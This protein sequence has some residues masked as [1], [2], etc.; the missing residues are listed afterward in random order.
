M[1]VSYYQILGIEKTAS[2]RDIKKAYRKLALAYH[3]DRNPGQPDIEKKFIEISTAYQVLTNSSER[4]KYD[5][6]LE[7]GD[8]ET[9]KTYW[10]NQTTKRRPPPPAYY[11]RKAGKVEYTKKAKIL[12]GIIVA[13]MLIIIV[14]VPIFL[15]RTTSKYN[16]AEAQLLYGKNFY[17]EALQKYDQSITEFGWKNAEACTFAGY[18]LTWN[19]QNPKRAMKYLKK[20]FK[21]NPNDSLKSTLHYLTGINLIKL[22]NKKNALEE[23]SLVYPNNS[24]IIDSASFHSGVILCTDQQNYKKSQDIFEKLVDKN[25][26][27]DDARYFLAYCQQKTGKHIDAIRNLDFL[28]DRNYKPGATYYHRA[29]SEIKLNQF[30]RACHDLKKAMKFGVKE[31]YALFSLHCSDR[32]P[33]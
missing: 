20:G 32:K 5:R 14:T 25:I 26:Y 18:I 6:S 3:P 28:I 9:F 30:D 19:L 10:E 12:G 16:Y 1:T 31:A 4:N 17:F 13:V 15:L 11:R 29:R 21:Y 2:L 7:T 8:V 24:S 22:D 27:F 33:L 23:L